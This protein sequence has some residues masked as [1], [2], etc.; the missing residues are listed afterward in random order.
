MKRLSI[1]LCFLFV[2]ITSTAR[3]QLPPVVE[4]LSNDYR[5]YVATTANTPS[6]PMVSHAPTC[7]CNHGGESFW[8]RRRGFA[9]KHAP[10]GIM[11]DHI[12]DPG[13]FMVEYKYMNM[14]M[15]GNRFG[16]QRVSD[17]QALAIGQGLGTNFGA[18]PT[19]MTMEMHMLHLMYGLS[20]NV[21]VYTM[22]MFPSI[23]MDHLRNTPFMANPPL[24]GTTFTT[25]NSGIGDTV[26]GALWQAC[27]DDQNEL[28]FNLAFSVPTG[29]IDRLTRTP[30]GGRGAL[31][32]PYP[33]RLGSGTFNFR[34]GVTY[35]RYMEQGSF[36]M[37]LQTDLPL[38]R[39]YDGYSV[40][41]E[42]RLSTWYSH[43]LTERLA[44]SFRVEN[45]WRSN[46]D[47]AD[48]DVMTTNPR[49]ISTND[50]NM[51]GGYWLNFGYGASLLVGDGHL[52]NVEITHPIY[53]DLEGIQLET[54]L[55][56]A[57]S[58]SKAF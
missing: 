27:K 12:H 26:F 39:N 34:P 10:A 9:D 23:T 19:H 7:R 31:E 3:A 33:M 41:D 49:V 11:G 8:E 30:T 16:D 28:I 40:S 57:A 55:T 48:R 46:F 24:A 29:D 56:L 15:D 47:G 4:P 13:E 35:K 32:F 22:L 53:Q 38:G 45:L 52:L 54:D 1:F 25:N 2:S 42:F 43:L 20:E 21:T 17:Q 36:G 5:E 18:T 37:Q 50:P 44:L 14:V 6:A 58:W 51:R